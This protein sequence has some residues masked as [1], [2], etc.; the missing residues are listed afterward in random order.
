MDASG[1]RDPVLFDALV[2]V[3]AGAASRTATKHRWGARAH[4][5]S[6]SRFSRYAGGDEHSPY[7]HVLTTTHQLA[8]D[9][10]TTPYPLIAEQLAVAEYARMRTWTLDQLRAREAELT[11][12]EHDLEAAENRATQR[13]A[14]SQ[15]YEGAALMDVRKAEAHIERAAVRRLIAALLRRGRT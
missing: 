5:V 12:A 10:E 1:R 4:G 6:R 7:T 15:D 13:L 8:A 3:G 14:E 2:S 11:D 9:P